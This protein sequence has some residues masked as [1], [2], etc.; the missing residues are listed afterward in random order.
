MSEYLAKRP[1]IWIYVGFAGIIGCLAFMV[2]IAV[3]NNPAEVPIARPEA[4]VG[5]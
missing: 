1:W 3:I 2:Y 4:Y 5:H